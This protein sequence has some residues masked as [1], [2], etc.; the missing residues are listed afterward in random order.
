[1]RGV[2]RGKAISG[3]KYEQTKRMGLSN[4]GERKEKKECSSTVDRDL[5]KHEEGKRKKMK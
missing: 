2:Q 5:K 3:G 1:V 4:G